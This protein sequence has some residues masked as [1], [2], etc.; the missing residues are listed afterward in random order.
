MNAQNNILLPPPKF[1]HMMIWR[2]N[3]FICFATKIY[4][5]IPSIREF[6][7]T[8]T[9]LQLKTVLIAQKRKEKEWLYRSRPFGT[10]T[11]NQSNNS[12]PSTR[13]TS[14]K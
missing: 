13:Q 14:S 4:F 11:S 12:S 3:D 6:K 8:F 2:D 1:R 5:S 9:Q 10:W 7:L